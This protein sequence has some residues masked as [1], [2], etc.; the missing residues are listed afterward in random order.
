[1]SFPLFSHEVLVHCGMSFNNE[2]SVAG[3]SRSLNRNVSSPTSNHTEDP[4]FW[5]PAGTSAGHC[6]DIHSGRLF[7]HS[8]FQ[9]NIDA[10]N[11]KQ[12]IL[13]PKHQHHQRAATAHS[14]CL[15]IRFQLFGLISMSSCRQQVLPDPKWHRCKLSLITRK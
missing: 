11:S 9:L 13:S 6:S 3:S 7:I 10:V 1:M 12:M 5:V 15:S 14:H 8:T 4:T 2:S